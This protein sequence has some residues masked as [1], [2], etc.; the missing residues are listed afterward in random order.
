MDLKER[1]IKFHEEQN[2]KYKDIA[3]AC[4]IPFSMMY[5]FTGGYRDLKSPA[6]ARLDEYLRAKGY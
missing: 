4:V 3:Q 1:V 5:N 2:V 6:A